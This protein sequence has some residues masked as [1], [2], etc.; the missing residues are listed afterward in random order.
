MQ[1]SLRTRIAFCLLAASHFGFA[2][3]TIHPE[4]N[5]SNGAHYLAPDD[6]AAIY[7]LS[8][9]FSAGFNGAGQKLVIVGQT[10]IALSDISSFRTQFGLPASAPKLVLF[11]ADPGIQAGDEIE[12]DLDIEWAGAV[13]RNATIIYV[14]SQN[15]FSSLQY[16]VDQ[17][18]AP[19]ISMS[20][21]ECETAASASLRT[22]AQQAN[23]QGITWLNASGDS[24]AAGCDWDASIATHGPAVASPADIPEVTAVGGTEF[25]ETGN[26]GWN[27]QN[28]LFWGSAAG[29]LPEKAWNDSANGL[30]LAASGGGASTVFNKPWWQNGP[31]VPADGARDVPD[32]SLS[33]SAS[34]DGYFIYTGGSLRTIGGTSAAAPSFAGIVTLL[35][36][37]VVSKGLQSAPGLGNINPV[38]YNI[39]QST[40]G[41]IHDITVGDNIVPCAHGSQGCA[42]GSFGFKA[43]PGYDLVT[44][45]GSVDA[46]HLATKWN[47]S[48]VLGT[49]LSL[50]SSTANVV[51]GGSAVLTA[52][53]APVSGAN[54]PTG[55]VAFTNAG[56][57]ALGS[58]AIVISGSISKASLTVGSSL[59]A[60]GANVITASYTSAGNFGS[61]SAATTLDL[62]IPAAVTT[63]FLVASPSSIAPTAS[64]QLTATVKAAT[65]NN[66]P[67]GPVTFVLGNAL[68]GTANL[69]GAGTTGT[70]TLS[71]PGSS[72][73][74]GSNTVKAS[75]AAT[76]S[77]TASS[78]TA[79]VTVVAPVSTITS[80]IASPASIAPGG[81]TQLSATVKPATGGISPAGLITFTV[82]TATLGTASLSTAGV[83]VLTVKSTQLSNG[84][85]IITATFAGAANFTGS[86]ATTVVN[87]V[88]SISTAT[89][90]TTS[91]AV[92]PG[93]GSIQLKA[94][95]SPLSGSLAPTGLVT[96][97][98]GTTI[99][100]TSTLVAS[101]AT[102]SATLAVSASNFSGSGANYSVVATYSGGT[103]F[104]PSTS[105]SAMITLPSVTVSTLTV[106]TASPATLTSTASTQLSITVRAAGGAASPTGT[107][108]VTS[109][110]ISLGSATL[111]ASTSATATAVL[112]I[113]GSSLALGTQ[114]LSVAYSGGTGFA[115]STAALNIT[116][117][118]H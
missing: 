36:Q 83:A 51:P 113:K 39:A 94:A 30:G 82:G 112:T 70:A 44:G 91:S 103:T 38:L 104:A 68:L 23:A 89:T 61:S 21:G 64:V 96:F 31:G 53:I 88:V 22:I 60:A 118:A 115:A 52:L 1:L 73:T 48:I 46:F 13:A 109:G 2:Q 102:A 37:Y 108:T 40:T 80:L 97:S 12:A 43:G 29:Y 84:G 3:K 77:F 67:V 114:T 9:L 69:V 87:V 65:G 14:Y 5:G 32:V 93:T 75:F 110:K 98:A 95:V 18:L 19:V 25:N 7:D 49:T 107:V 35:N 54:P 92:L 76:A 57:T 74:I 20:Y 85:N 8:P 90:L 63:T 66:G 116:V 42:T 99:L 45:L 6:F 86:T 117:A 101:G 41:A 105:S 34:H 81:A 47:N 59:L 72:L 50:T 62:A 100:G 4:F 55:S 15:V 11:G 33:A 17:N 26:T 27:L 56:G 24:G 78:G 71:V 79:A 16:A 10:D 28:G 111:S 106:A 58:A